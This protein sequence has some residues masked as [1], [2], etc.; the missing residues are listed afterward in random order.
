MN[1]QIQQAS[2]TEQD[3][4][5][6]QSGLL[7]QSPEE[8]SWL[9]PHSMDSC[10]F[11]DDDLMDME[12]RIDDCHCSLNDLDH[13]EMP[14]EPKAQDNDYICPKCKDE[15]VVRF[16]LKLLGLTYDRDEGNK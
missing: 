9:K 4:L 3:E 5:L 15:C 1:N 8:D 7:E 13:E 16:A 11:E 14:L 6:S 10:Q 2:Y 12:S